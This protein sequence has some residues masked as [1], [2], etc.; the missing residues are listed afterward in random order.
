MNGRPL[1]EVYLEVEDLAL[2]YILYRNAF[3]Y[4]LNKDVFEQIAN[5]EPGKISTSKRRV[6]E[7]L[8]K[9]GLLP[10]VVPNFGI[11]ATKPV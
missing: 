1:L 6:F 10:H 11:L 8:A 5:F 9:L 2:Q 7:V 3:L 4:H